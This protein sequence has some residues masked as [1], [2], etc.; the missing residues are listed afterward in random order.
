MNKLT[1]YQGKQFGECTNF[2]GSKPK[3]QCKAKYF[4]ENEV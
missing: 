2:L 1:S 3:Y 4:G